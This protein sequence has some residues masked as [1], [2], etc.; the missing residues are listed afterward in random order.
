V[1]VGIVGLG[2]MGSALA[3]NLVG[4][5]LDLVAFD[6][7]G[8]GRCPGGAKFAPSVGNLVRDAEVLVLSLPD[9]LA[10]R[11]VV[12]ATVGEARRSVQ[13]VL[14]TSTIGVTAAEENARVLGSV[15]ASYVD[16]PVSGGVAGARARTLSV[17]YAGPKDACD[18]VEPI[19][20]GLSDRRQRVGERA[21]MA[22]ALKLA[23]NFLSATTLL[24][25]SEAV[26]FG[27][28]A[29]LDMGTM[30]E[31]LNSSSGQSGATSDKFPR[32]VLTGTYAA[33]FTNSLMSKD[34]Q[35]YVEAVREQN[36]PSVLGPLISSVWQQFSESDPA[37]DFTRIYPFVQQMGG[38]ETTAD[39]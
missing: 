24:A 33:G 39:L 3:E 22:Q 14:D 30:L 19:L 11:Q 35:L 36:A 9:G 13:H 38:T 15:S 10:S 8:P 1:I 25:T 12:L 20:A 2:N 18:A 28:S 29:G 5:G 34:M 27:L 32:H 6:V 23:N 7:A 17:M 37:V 16:A 31:V 4:A 21:G 26:S